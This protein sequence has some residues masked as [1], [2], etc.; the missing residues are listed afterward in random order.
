MGAGAVRFALGVSA[1]TLLA[2]GGPGLLSLAA[3]ECSHCP[4]PQRAGADAATTPAAAQRQ[5]RACWLS[6]C[7]PLRPVRPS[8]GGWQPSNGSWRVQGL[9]LRV[10]AALRRCLVGANGQLRG[11]GWQ[12]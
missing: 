1:G 4:P 11:I 9:C 2:A 6:S 10:E 7:T 5:G 3:A 8:I 12:T